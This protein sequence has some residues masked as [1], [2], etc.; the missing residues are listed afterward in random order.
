MS[1]F[2]VWKVSLKGPVAYRHTFVNF[3]NVTISPSFTSL[4]SPVSTCVA[5]LGDRFLV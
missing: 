5:A 4:Q 2:L 3:E 1:L